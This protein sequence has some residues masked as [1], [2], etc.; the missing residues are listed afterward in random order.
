MSGAPTASGG[1]YPAGPQTAV[2]AIV[3]RADTVLLVK[4]A[5]PPGRGLWAIPGGRVKLGETLEQAAKREVREETGVIIRPQE[6]IYI[7]EVIDRD[8]A[9]GVRFH[10]VIVDLLADY[11]SGVP[12]PGTDA[13]EARWISSGELKELPVTK[14]TRELLKSRFQFG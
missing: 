2:G 14:T 4:R 13:S 11:L 5:N 10:Y 9:G 12:S 8:D 3:F 6:P 7:F 1:R